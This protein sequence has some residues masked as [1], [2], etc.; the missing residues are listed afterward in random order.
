M[1][2][3]KRSHSTHAWNM[4]VTMGWMKTQT[5]SWASVRASIKEDSQRT[6]TLTDS[7]K[8]ER[9]YEKE[10]STMHEDSCIGINYAQRFPK[11]FRSIHT[12]LGFALCFMSSILIIVAVT[13]YSIL[14]CTRIPCR[15]SHCENVSFEVL[16]LQFLRLSVWARVLVFVCC[17]F[18]TTHH[19]M[20]HNRMLSQP[21]QRITTCHDENKRWNAGDETA[22][23]KSHERSDAR[24]DE[25][26]GRDVRRREKEE[27]QKQWKV[28]GKWLSWLLAR[29]K[30]ET[31]FLVDF[32]MCKR[33][34][35]SWG[36]AGELRNNFRREAGTVRGAE[37]MARDCR[38]RDQHNNQNRQS[39]GWS[40]TDKQ[41]WQGQ[42]QAWQWQRKE[43]EQRWRQNKLQ[44]KKE[45]IS[46]DGG[47]W[48]WNHRLGE[49]KT[50]TIQHGGLTFGTQTCGMTCHGNKL[51]KWF[52]HHLFKT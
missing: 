49:V 52:D 6:T 40:G 5:W 41:A 27:T 11:C 24:S 26:G 48:P 9:E 47:A 37:C 22:D 30:R 29:Q 15:D 3:S 43:Q 23:E 2:R 17:L 32:L 19:N 18:S 44:E 8:R 12:L 46:W 21:Q 31:S 45:R 33:T 42:K 28:S 16:S 7:K 39:S 35:L 38:K 50:K 14:T 36:F 13:T 51:Y 25:R 10:G 20:T 1:E 4:S 34:L